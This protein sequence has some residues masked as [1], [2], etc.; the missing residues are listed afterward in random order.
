MFASLGAGS[1]THLA[2][3][4]SG[5]RLDGGGADA[6]HA[7]RGR[8]EGGLRAELA[9][10]RAVGDGVDAVTGDALANAIGADETHDAAMSP[11]SG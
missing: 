9:R 1:I 5:K 7:V 11:T 3:R 2:R 6:Q 8:V 4:A 10:R